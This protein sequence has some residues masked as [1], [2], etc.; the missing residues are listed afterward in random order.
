MQG[1]QS[2]D[3]NYLQRAPYTLLEAL[4]NSLSMGWGGLLLNFYLVLNAFTGGPLSG[5]WPALC[6]L[7]L[8]VTGWFLIIDV[9]SILLLPLFHP[10]SNAE[11]IRDWAQQ[12]YY[13]QDF[14]PPKG[15]KADEL[16]AVPKS[17]IPGTL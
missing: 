9:F 3:G 8:C 10:F 1:K 7:I 16:R 13:R 15:Y 17:D 4:L 14:G 6:M 2:K 12:G 5:A 11:R